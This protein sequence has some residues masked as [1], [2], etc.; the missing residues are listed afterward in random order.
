[1]NFF[2]N[3]SDTG[4]KLLIAAGVI[5][6]IALCDRLAI[7]PAMSRLQAIDQDIA[8]E[9]GDIKQDIHFLQ[10]KNKILKESEALAP[11]ITA[12]IPAE[13]EIIAAFLKR[14]EMLASKAN[15]NVIKVTPSTGTQ[16]TDYWKYT[17]DLECSGKL[18]DVVTFM[19]LINTSNDLMKVAK[20][21]FSSKKDSDDLKASMTI[22]KVGIGK[23]PMPV[24]ANPAGDADGKTTEAAASG[25]SASASSPSGK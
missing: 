2:A 19:H 10:Y 20:F 22:V 4:K 17:A 11:Y 16:D 1:M 21:N 13:E 3:L 8:K 24:P 15:V 14:L 7:A 23:R 9:E 25:T 12:T 6:V 5:V 18:A